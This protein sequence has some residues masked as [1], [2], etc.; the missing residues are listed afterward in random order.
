MLARVPFA[1]PAGSS[2]FSEPN[3][4]LECMRTTG[5]GAACSV[6]VSVRAVPS[7]APRAPQHTSSLAPL[8]LSS[9]VRAPTRRGAARLALRQNVAPHG[10]AAV[11]TADGVNGA[12]PKGAG[13]PEAS[14]FPQAAQARQAKWVASDTR[15]SRF[16]ASPLLCVYKCSAFSHVRALY[17]RQRRC[18]V[19]AGT[20]GRLA[21]GCACAG[22][23]P[24]VFHT[25]VSVARVHRH[26]VRCI[27]ADCGP[28]HRTSTKHR[29][30]PGLASG[31]HARAPPCWL[32]PSQFVRA[33]YPDAR[34]VS[35]C[36]HH[37]FPHAQ[38]APPILVKILSHPPPA[39]EV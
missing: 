26:G 20:A 14:T 29:H 28:C 38:M 15:T 39:S 32:R 27:A 22:R 21:V 12:L 7:P 2:L 5:S 31:A 3:F 23:Q 17:P 16:L 33:A 18:H 4:W 10:T 13:L 37:L 24:A 6:C 11:V 9:T 35:L 1:A 30:S 36:H 34:A 8:G 19:H 25:A